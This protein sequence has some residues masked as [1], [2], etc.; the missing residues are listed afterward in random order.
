MTIATIRSTASKHPDARVRQR[1]ATWLFGVAALVLAMAMI[2][3]ATRLTESGLSMVR[4]EPLNVFPPTN[5]QAWLAELE[6]YRASP[7]YQQVNRG[8][9]LDA[10]KAIFWWEF[11]HR[12]M[13]RLIGLAFALP[14][15]Y[16]ALTRQI[17]KGFGKR[18]LGLLA[19][20]GLQGGI[21]WWMV[22]SGLVNEPAVSH[23]RLTVHLCLAL[24]IFA[25]LIWTA[26]DLISTQGQQGP[27]KGGDRRLK[28]MSAA[29]LG[30]L[31]V[32][33][34][35]GG[36]V[37]GLDAGFAFNSWPLM[38]DKFMPDETWA[39]EPWFANVHANPVTVQFLHR[40]LAY[41][42]VGHGLALAARA[43]RLG[44]RLGDAPLQRL[45][46]ALALVVVAQTLLGIFTVVYGVPV[47]L[48]TAH[49]GGAIVLLG[50]SVALTHRAW[51]GGLDARLQE[52]LA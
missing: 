14:L 38:G 39:L 10:F 12:Q 31:S 17:P 22:A 40:L 20:G 45:G 29:M 44:G 43:W 3:A 33:I 7:Q 34:I 18:L 24:L 50:V 6:A 23:Y 46:L 13:G 9:S 27:S 19:L 32:Q 41:L 16:F 42:L 15:L 37:A 4:W 28:S 8:M 25:L 21:G 2:G 35:L 30:V 5:E 51:H 47:W 49:Q 36:F 48:G 11:I 52:A 26:L 1:L